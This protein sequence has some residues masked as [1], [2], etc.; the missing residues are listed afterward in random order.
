MITSKNTSTKL[1]KTDKH[2]NAEGTTITMKMYKSLILVVITIIAVL[3]GNGNV[4]TVRAAVKPEI[5]LTSYSLSDEIVFGEETLISV[6]FK[7]TVYHS[8][9]AFVRLPISRLFLLLGIRISFL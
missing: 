9:I 4:K 6:T 3:F 2:K 8:I 1:R 7:N 5:V